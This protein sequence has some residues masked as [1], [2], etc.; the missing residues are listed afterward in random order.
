MTSPSPGLGGWAPDM[1]LAGPEWATATPAQQAAAQQVAVHTL[2]A[3]SG[4]QYG[5]ANVVLA[6]WIPYAAPYFYRSYGYPWVQPYLI[7]KFDRAKRVLLPGPVASITEVRYAAGDPDSGGRTILTVETDYHLD[8]D[9]HLVK[10]NGI[11]ASQNLHAPVFTVTY[12]RGLAVPAA[13]NVA[14]GIYAAEWLKGH[15]GNPQS[16]L[17]S[18]TREAARAGVQVSLASPETL[19]NAGLTGVPEVDIFLRTVNP[20][21]RQASP[22]LWSP[23]VGT[24]RILSESPVSA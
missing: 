12:V 4:R 1:G 9:G 2:W 19:A 21:K 14:A 13:A 24:H 6:P 5:Q 10:V 20:D 3:L 15:T 16:R 18:R 8:P 7:S 17:P 23:E 22:V 11:W